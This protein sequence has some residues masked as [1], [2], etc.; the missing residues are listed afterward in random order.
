M[1]ASG[2]IHFSTFLTRLLTKITIYHGPSFL[3]KYAVI[4]KLNGIFIYASYVF[5]SCVSVVYNDNGAVE[6]T[7]SRQVTKLEFPVRRA[8]G[9]L[10]DVTVQWSLYQNDSSDSMEIVW[11]KSGQVSLA[12]GQWNDSFIINVASDKKE[13]H[14][15]VVW[16]QLDK[17]TGGAVLASRDQTTAKIL[18]TGNEGKSGAWRW[19]VTGV[20]CGVFLIVVGVLVYWLHKKKQESQRY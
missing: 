1:L 17:T 9:S 14:E 20:C 6:V 13:V 7:R 12:D 18:I 15:S 11:P 10:G 3:Q 8:K 4:S 2:H 19:I 16:I 5:I